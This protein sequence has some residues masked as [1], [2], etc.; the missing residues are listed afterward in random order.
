MS[1]QKRG[2]KYY[3]RVRVPTNLRPLIGRREIIKSLD[4]TQYSEAR[5]RS[6]P[7]EAHVQKLFTVID[8]NKHRM[9]LGDISRLVHQYIH[10]SLE[11]GEEER[12]ARKGL[13]TE[14]H[15]AITGFITDE[16]SA[17]TNALMYNGVESITQTADALLSANG[18]Q[19]DRESDEYKR[20]C[21][22]LLKAHVE[23]LKTE[24]RRW[25]GDYGTPPPGLAHTA[26]AQP[27][28]PTGNVK[29]LSE[30]IADFV[31]HKESDK[32]WA[33]RTG[34]M[35]KS[36]LAIFLEVVGDK[37]ITEITKTDIRG[38]KETL[39][40]IPKNMSLKYPG[41][42]IAEVLTLGAVPVLS[43][44]SVDKLMR[45]VK[46]LFIFATEQDYIE[47]NPATLRL[48]AKADAQ[49][50]RKAFDDE[51]IRVIFEGDYA[52]S[53]RKRPDR[54]WI[55]LILLHSGARLEEIAQLDVADLKQTD[56][57]WVFDLREEG[58]KALKT[59][60]S[61]RSVP[62]HPLLLKLGLLDYAA[63]IRKQGAVKLWPL[64]TKSANGYGSAISKWFNRRLR[65]LG[66]T[67]ARK[68]LYSTRH[69]VATKLKQLDVQDSRVSELLGHK[70][71]GETFGRYGKQLNVR[72]L[73]EIVGK[74]DF[75]LDGLTQKA[76][77]SSNVH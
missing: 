17:G 38:Y 14:E 69:T 45:Y 76:R 16:I 51:D 70:V 62:V 46:S 5:A 52:A 19:F 44:S 48:K 22:D 56:G 41:K 59:A 28:Q 9:S 72:R 15:E 58:D 77:G 64:L 4:T 55:P 43:S 73:A 24:L 3:S 40:R 33:Y 75:G 66:V 8:E 39:H 71:E 11:A 57:V 61:R 35:F 30:V 67:D 49:E 50:Q 6:M 10:T 36:G 34:V 23:V 20:F 21:R 60:E 37:P 68:V 32:S 29:L 25:E 63:D 53:L 27:Q 65:E 7:W 26:G 13:S 18:I 42:P 47:K 31:R 1:T 74:L 12:V 54:F 2:K